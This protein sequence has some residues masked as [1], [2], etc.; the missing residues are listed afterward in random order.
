[1]PAAWNKLL[2]MLSIV[3]TGWKWLWI[4]LLGLVSLVVLLFLASMLYFL[5]VKF[6]RH[7][8]GSLT[9]NLDKEEAMP[10]IPRSNS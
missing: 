5:Y 4:P 1:L 6:I 3:F 2:L 9:E 10:R 8:S 7:S